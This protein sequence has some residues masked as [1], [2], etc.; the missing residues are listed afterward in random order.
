VFVRKDTTTTPL[1][2][3]AT[4]RVDVIELAGTAATATESII[5]NGDPSAPD[6]DSPDIDSREVYTPDI[7]SPDIDSLAVNS[8]DIDSPDIDSPDIDSTT[9]MSLG[10]GTPDI[11]SPDIDSPDIDSPDI[12]STEIDSPETGNPDI[13]SVPITDFKVSLTNGGNTTAHYNATSLIQNA[14]LNAY[15]YQLIVRRRYELRAVGGDCLPTTIPT[16]KVLVNLVDVDPKTPDIDSPDIDS[17]APGTATFPVAPGEKVDVIVRV[18]QNRP[19]RSA[20]DRSKSRG[21][22]AAGRSQHGRRGR[23]NH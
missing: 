5:L 21:R 14:T 18:R 15:R 19:V 4:V 11:D 23:R 8:P 9:L 22:D 16:T 6:I 10:L 3:K 17:S 7:D 2:P 13:D 20:T 1:D 12:D